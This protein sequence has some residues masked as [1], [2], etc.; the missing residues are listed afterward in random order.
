MHHCVRWFGM[1]LR[2]P[3]VRLPGL[4]APA[5]GA[6]LALSLFVA[7]S[8]ATA[9]SVLIDF[10][11]AS[12]SSISLLGGII[13]TPPDGSIDSA[14]G[15]LSLEASSLT[16]FIS[17]GQ[18]VLDQIT[19][20]GAIAKNVGGVADISGPIDGTQVGT[21]N[22]TL[23]GGQT[24][25]SFPGTIAI[26]LNANF[27]C[28]GSGCASLGFPVVDSGLFNLTA[29]ILPIS[30]IG[31]I[32]NAQITA[33]IPIA[34]GGVLGVLHLVGIETGRSFVPEPTTALLLG[35]GL[36]VVRKKQR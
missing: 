24:S 12:Q 26:N 2:L 8:P 5:R 29:G 6:A 1:L 25:L 27:A 15:R 9:A 22:G 17:G 7:A 4:G 32:G 10:D 34:L 33:D 18:A 28:A 13:T 11:F 14:S 3:E 23:T 16:T 20:S 30:G 31:T 21:L 19:F 35:L 36:L